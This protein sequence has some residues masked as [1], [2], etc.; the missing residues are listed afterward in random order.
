MYAVLSF[1]VPPILNVSD[2][3]L[4]AKI[5]FLNLVVTVEGGFIIWPIWQPYA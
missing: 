3:P 4:S 2:R 5:K 1:E